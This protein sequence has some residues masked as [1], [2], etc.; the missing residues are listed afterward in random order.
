MQIFAIGRKLLL[1]LVTKPDQEGEMTWWWWDPTTEEH[2]AYD[3]ME[4]SGDGAVLWALL[5]ALRAGMALATD[6]LLRT[7]GPDGRLGS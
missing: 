5:W 3:G 1:Q 4:W 7:G 6:D 2:L